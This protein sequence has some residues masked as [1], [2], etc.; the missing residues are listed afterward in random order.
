MRNTVTGTYKIII[1]SL[2]IVQ[3][4]QVLNTACSIE[5]R[6]YQCLFIFNINMISYTYL[7]HK[8]DFIQ[9]D[10]YL[11]AIRKNERTLEIELVPSYQIMLFQFRILPL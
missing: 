3:H 5:I 8:S 7:H 2:N 4:E 6:K 11:R 10:R 1:Y 9:I